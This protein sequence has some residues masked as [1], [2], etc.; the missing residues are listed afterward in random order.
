MASPSPLVTERLSGELRQ[1]VT[2]LCWSP[3]GEFLAMA[4]AGGEMLL[5]DFRAGCEELLRGDRDSSI[6]AIGFSA[7]GQFLMAVGQAGEL[8]LWQLGDPGTRPMALDPMPLNRGWLDAAS[9]QPGGLLLAVAAGRDVRLWDGAGRQWREEVL[10]LPGTVLSL[11]WSADG[12]RLAASCHGQVVLWEL[13]GSSPPK[14]PIRATI[15]STG[16]SL[17]F[18][19]IGALLACGQMDRSLLLW[20]RGGEGEPWQFSGFP[21]KVRSLAWSDQPGR[22]APLL[23]VGAGDLLV[24]W[25]QVNQGSKGWRPEPLIWHQHTIQ[26]VAFAPGSTL[27]ASAATDG[28]LAL[29]DKRGQLLQP[30]EADG[31]GFT[32]LSWRPDGRHLAAGGDQGRWWLWP[33]AVPEGERRHR[34]ARVGFGCAP[35]AEADGSVRPFR[36]GPTR[37]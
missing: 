19:P 13:T 8:L 5:L 24:L 33:V 15:G 25:S 16:L 22:F 12:R 26:A 29:W 20:P 14:P 34:S 35:S 3:D 18:S 17:A 1:P 27:L 6:D 2:A 10:E 4:S 7:D 30:L 23:A 31:Q 28:T 32:A 21:A 9:W 11:A 36:P 37:R